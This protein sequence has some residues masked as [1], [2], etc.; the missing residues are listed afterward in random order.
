[1]MKWSKERVIP[2]NIDTVWNLFELENIQRIMPNVVEHKLIEAKEGVVGSKYQQKYREGKRVETYIV[3]DLEY[4]NTDTKKHKRIGFT[5]AKIFNIEAAFTLIKVD[6]NHTRFIYQ[7]HNEGANFVG[8]MMLK[9]SGQKENEKVVTGFMDL[10]EKEAI[11][12]AASQ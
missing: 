12:E 6:E 7:G 2:V 11:K 3:E 1:M 10:V 5:L 8:R 9:M 4:E